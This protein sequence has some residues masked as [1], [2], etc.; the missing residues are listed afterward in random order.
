M[1]EKIQQYAKEYKNAIGDIMREGVKLRNPYGNY[2]EQKIKFMACSHGINFSD[3][4]RT[5][6]NLFVGRSTE[7]IAER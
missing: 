6:Q 1:A 4:F 5:C 7:Q 2:T 3:Y